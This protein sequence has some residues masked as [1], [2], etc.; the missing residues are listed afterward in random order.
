MI[1][2]NTV[3]IIFKVNISKYIV[4]DV[5]LSVSVIKISLYNQTLPCYQ[6][7]SHETN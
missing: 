2:V 5:E 6:S 1:E 3:E 7:F 4:F